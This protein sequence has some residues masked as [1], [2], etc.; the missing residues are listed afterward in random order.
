MQGFFEGPSQGA[1]QAGEDLVPDGEGGQVHPGFNAE[2]TEEVTQQ[3]FRVVRDGLVEAQVKLLTGKHG[4]PASEL[5]EIVTVG[6]GPLV[7]KARA[8]LAVGDGLEGRRPAGKA[9]LV[10][11]VIVL[12]M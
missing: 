9:G 11:S 7:S 10:V 4:Q 12:G 5:P 6:K 8:P 1:G 2:K 3:R